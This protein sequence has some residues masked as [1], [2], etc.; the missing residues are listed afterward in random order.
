M[1]LFRDHN[2]SFVLNK[3][4]L[5]QTTVITFIYLLALFIV[6]NFKK[7]LTTDP[8]L[9]RYTIFG[10]KVLHFPQTI[11]FFLENY[12]HHSHLRISPFHCAKLKK[13]SSSR[14]VMRICNLWV[15]NGP[16]PQIRMFFRKPV[17][18]PC[19]FY[20]CLSTCQKSNSEINL[21]VKYWWLKNTEISLAESH[22][23][24]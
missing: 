16:F 23:C 13:N 8:E 19:L 6:K 5:V 10:P 12:Y 21:L 22:F 1:H 3:K 15:Q 14:S 2:S 11:F 17:N 4:F 20:S 24:L 18:Q 9:W 7:I